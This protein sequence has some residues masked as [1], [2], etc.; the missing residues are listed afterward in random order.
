MLRGV[1]RQ[2]QFNT[3]HKNIGISLGIWVRFPSLM[4]DK[5]IQISQGNDPPTETV[6]LFED[7]KQTE[8]HAYSV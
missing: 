2:Q 3:S 8:R 6:E 1:F 4:E 7:L 5:L